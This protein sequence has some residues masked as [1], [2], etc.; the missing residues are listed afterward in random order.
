MV[1]HSTFLVR[2]FPFQAHGTELRAVRRKSSEF[3]RVGI[4]LAVLRRVIGR[5]DGKYAGPTFE[6]D[7][8]R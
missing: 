3:D 4:H 1:R 6:H 8:L 5:G 2:L 7:A